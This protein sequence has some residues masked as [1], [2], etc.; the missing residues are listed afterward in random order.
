M[1]R[2][3]SSIMPSWLRHRQILT[4]EAVLVVGA[5]MELLQRWIT[6]RPEVPWWGK[7]L[8]VMLVNAGMLGGVL[9]LFTV[10]A[11]GSLSGATRAVQAVPL[12]A[13]LLLLH[14]LVGAG[15]FALYAWVWEFWPVAAQAA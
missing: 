2:K 14:L 6:A 10:L 13:P 3:R 9:L 12:P 15:I 5:G 4:T 8:E 7:T 11:R 1:A